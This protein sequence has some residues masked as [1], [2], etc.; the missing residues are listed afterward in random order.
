M[1][2]PLYLGVPSVGPTG[3]S[4]LPGLCSSALCL[5]GQPGAIAVTVAVS[6]PLLLPKTAGG[7][8]QAVGD[9]EVQGAQ[10]LACS[11]WAADGPGAQSPDGEPRHVAGAFR[12]PGRPALPVPRPRPWGDS[13]G[14]FLPQGSC[15]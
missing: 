11:L 3:P 1:F 14:A 9:T 5:S 15:R 13:F 10:R 12:S 6:R 4:P 7:P 2:V 8:Q